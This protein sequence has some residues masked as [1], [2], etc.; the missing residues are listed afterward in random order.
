MCKCLDHNRTRKHPPHYFLVSIPLSLEQH[1]RRVLRK[2]LRFWIKGLIDRKLFF[3]VQRIK[4]YQEYWKVKIAF[5]S[6]LKKK[7]IS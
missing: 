5:I 7:G 4:K 3:L 1:C 6:N 2:C